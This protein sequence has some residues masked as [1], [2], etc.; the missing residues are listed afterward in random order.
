[1][2]WTFH[3]V[4]IWLELMNVDGHDAIEADDITVMAERL[5]EP[6]RILPIDP[7]PPESTLPC[8]P[9]CISVSR[10]SPVYKVHH[11]RES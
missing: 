11:F 3:M 6:T 1:M 10:I 8:Y 9:L 2:F 7:F 4:S 5:F